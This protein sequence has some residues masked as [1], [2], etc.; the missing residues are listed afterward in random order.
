MTVDFS[1]KLS[2][3]ISPTMFWKVLVQHICDGWECQFS[4]I[5]CAGHPPGASAFQ[6]EQEGPAAAVK[7]FILS[8]I[9]RAL[10]LP[11]S[12]SYYLRKVMILNPKTEMKT[13]YYSLTS[14]FFIRKSTKYNHS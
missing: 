13:T 6:R 5:S 1:R 11:W 8:F 12:L 2:E 7:E 14:I 4:S 10:V 3:D 9:A